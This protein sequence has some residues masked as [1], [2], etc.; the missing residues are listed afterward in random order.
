MESIPPSYTPSPPSPSYSPS[1]PSPSYSTQLLPGEQ[2]VEETRR[3][4]L[5]TQN[6]GVFRRITDNIT[7]VLRDQRPGSIKPVYGRNGLVRGHIS[8]RSSEGLTEVTLKLEGHLRVET[9]GTTITTSVVSDSYPLWSS[10]STEPCPKTLPFTIFFPSAFMDGCQSRPLPPSFEDK[11]AT[12]GTCSYTLSVI[13]SRPRRFLSS[14]RSSDSL[15][16]PVCYHPCSRPHTP[17][18]PSD[19]PFMATVKS[20]PEEWHQVLSSM[21]ATKSSGLTPVQ[22]LLFIPSVQVYP[23][24]ETIPFHLQLRAPSS[25]LAQFIEKSVPDRGLP[26]PLSGEISIRVYLLRQVV[27]KVFEEQR[28]SS[29]ILGEGKLTYSAP[30]PENHHSYRNV[31]LGEGIDCLDW[32]GE[33]RCTEDVTVASF[34]TSVLS[35]RDFIVLS[36]EPLQPINCPL[37][38]S[39]HYHPIRLVTDPWSEHAVT[40]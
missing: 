37:L 6:T 14:F 36:L 11:L 34:T 17:M 9:S 26:V 40:W 29:R 20:S 4:A 31:P 16:V 2:T 8:L 28:S 7:L 3:Q 25:S 38:A 5:Q 15:V 35:V 32:D 24:S 33:L 12:A 1:P 19:A 22:C 23:L 18:L 10:S 39:K 21:N 13:V 30:L 27:R